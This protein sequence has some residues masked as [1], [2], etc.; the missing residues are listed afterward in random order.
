MKTIFCYL[1]FFIELLVF[2]CTLNAQWQQVTMPSSHGGTVYSI[3]FKDSLMFAGI[4]GGVF[5]SSD[6]GEHWKK[7]NPDL[8]PRENGAVVFSLALT[9]E[10]LI[11]A[12]N[13]PG[14]YISSDEGRNWS[15][16]N[17]NENLRSTPF[18]IAADKNFII[19]GNFAKNTY[20]SYDNG[21]TWEL[22][23]LPGLSGLAIKDSIVLAQSNLPNNEGIYL[24]TNYGSTWSKVHSASSYMS[25]N[26]WKTAD[27]FSDSLAF[28][29]IDNYLADSYILR[30]SNNGFTW[31]DSSYLNCTSIYS[32]VACPIDTLNNF[33]FA[34]TD[35]GL[36][37]SSDYG[38]NWSL[39]N[40]GIN[41]TYIL[42]LTYNNK[43]NLLYAGTGDGIYC[44]SDNGESWNV[45]GNPSEWIFT[46]SGSDIFATSSNEEYLFNNKNYQTV[47]Y[48]STDRGYSWTETFSGY[49][50]NTSKIISW[51]ASLN[52][53]GNINLYAITEQFTTDINPI[54]YNTIIM[55]HD[56]GK[57]WEKIYPDTTDRFSEIESYSPGFLI[58]AS[59]L[60]TG[61]YYNYLGAIL[62]SNDYGNTW[63]IV[64][65][66]SSFTTFS[67]DGDKIYAA[68]SNIDVSIIPPRNIVKKI[69][70][71]VIVSD[72]MGLSWDKVKSPLDSATVL[73]DELTDT[74][75]I[76]SSSY[77]KDSHLL[78]GARAYNFYEWVGSAP[79]ANGGG[80]YHL[81]KNGEEW[82]IVESSFV[83]KSIFGFE[84]SGNDI[85]AA[86][87]TGVFHSNDYGSNWNDISS[88]MKNIYVSSLFKTD[89]YLFANS[90]NGIWKRSLSEITSVDRDRTSRGIPNQFYLSQNYPNPF[91]PTTKINYSV[92]VS[93][94][95]SL[96]VYNVLG[97][98]VKTI[99][100][101]YKQAGN[102]EVT[103]NGSGLASGVYLY[104]LQSEK[105]SI[106]KKFVLLK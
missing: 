48:H 8:P 46:S 92:P 36:Y 9:G 81:I 14:V 104:R 53:L 47:I 18:E 55:S 19:G 61:T 40:N 73:N 87:N 60:F 20:K 56:F 49:L 95:I 79:S 44:S 23:T 29:G 43:G 21:L 57:S 35:S 30:S 51:D 45:I 34:G 77:A 66:S 99:F 68:G 93:G 69:I 97:Q 94:N 65:T 24:S 5:V 2:T 74:L 37:R 71:S 50:F 58:V 63:N 16:A 103:F 96:K 98:E 28:V 17:I 70:N 31:F 10:T 4:S 85:Y 105:V 86:T 7:V 33:I 76:I 83:G 75:S 41:S 106:F 32:I 91:N 54:I 82:D 62:L 6:N 11:A 15:K 39:L 84:S 80:L 22:D 72:D 42:S 25:W 90:I 67:F 12:F 100:E 102:Y 52:D 64:D 89:N 88:G 101:G 3:C 78:L 13:E 27:A 1:S 38:K 26:T 59:H